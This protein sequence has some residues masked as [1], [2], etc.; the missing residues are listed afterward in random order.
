MW[1]HEVFYADPFLIRLT[2]VFFFFGLLS[3]IISSG[4]RSASF[5][6]SVCSKGRESIMLVE[7]SDICSSGFSLA[8][9]WDAPSVSDGPDN[10]VDGSGS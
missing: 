2:S 9:L 6:T 1:R 10:A 8:L 7:L 5:R 3:S 4:T